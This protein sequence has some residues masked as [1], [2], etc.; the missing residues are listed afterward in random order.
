MAQKRSFFWSF[1]HFF[2]KFWNFSKKVEKCKKLKNSDFEGRFWSCSAS[3]SR[4][5]YCRILKIFRRSSRCGNKIGKF[6]TPNSFK[7]GPQNR[8]FSTFLL[9]QLFF[10]SIFILLFWSCSAW[11]T[12]DFYC[13]ILKISERTTR[14]GNKIEDFITPNSFKNA[15]RKWPF[16]T[17]NHQN[18]EI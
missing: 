11:W 16:F 10:G 18:L 15:P 4:L 12:C 7:N 13:R 9:M 2:E 6:M 3:W 17:K 5:F 8:D 14:C 1:M